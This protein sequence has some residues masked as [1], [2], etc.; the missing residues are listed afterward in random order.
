MATVN[1]P[2]KPAQ[3]FHQVKIHRKIWLSDFW[4]NEA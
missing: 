4:L 3:T 2:N 1:D